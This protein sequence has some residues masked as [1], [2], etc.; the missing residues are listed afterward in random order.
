M[1]QTLF[2]SLKE[3]QEPE[4]KNISS[5]CARRSRGPGTVWVSASTAFWR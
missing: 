3:E 4:K 1:I 5:A 2:G